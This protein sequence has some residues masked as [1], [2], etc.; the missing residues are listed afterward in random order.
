VL[1]KSICKK[2][3]S[4][5]DKIA[6]WRET[7]DEVLWASGVVMCPSKF[8]TEAMVRRTISDPPVAECPYKLEHAIA[9]SRGEGK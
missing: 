2:C 5:H 6:G 3:A 7:T 4:R 9:E 1:S 8:N